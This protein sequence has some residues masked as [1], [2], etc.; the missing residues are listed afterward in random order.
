MKDAGNKNNIEAV[1]FDFGGVIID[2]PLPGMIEYSASFLKVPLEKFDASR[3]KYLGDFARGK[4]PEAEFWKRIC[5]ELGI[6]VPQTNCSIWGAAFFHNYLL[7]DSMLDFVASLQENG[8]KTGLIS[9]TEPPALGSFVEDVRGRFD[10]CIYS[11]GVGYIKPEEKIYRCALEHLKVAPPSAVFI[12]DIA[13]YV[14][15]ARSVGMQ[16]IQFHSEEQIK[17]ELAGLG[18]KV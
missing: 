13:E 12:D 2:N 15:G 7:R 17:E 11:C 10:S 18:V 4:L 14:Q 6:K 9:N 3:R 8:Y 5:G 1:I 16:G